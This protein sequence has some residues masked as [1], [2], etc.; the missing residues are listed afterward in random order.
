[1]AARHLPWVLDEQSQPRPQL[2]VAAHWPG[3]G[4]SLSSLSCYF[5][6]NNPRSSSVA[7]VGASLRNAVSRHW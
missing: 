5:T 1:M 3:I 6:V 2:E 7:L 4:S